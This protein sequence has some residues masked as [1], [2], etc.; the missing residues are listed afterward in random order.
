MIKYNENVIILL[1]FSN[2][3]PDTMLWTLCYRSSAYRTL[4]RDTTGPHR[5]C[6]GGT[7]GHPRLGL[8]L[9]YQVGIAV[10]PLG[11]L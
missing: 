7:K 4:P 8:V 11:A 1:G 6:S 2:F 3:L 9:L 10:S 5:H